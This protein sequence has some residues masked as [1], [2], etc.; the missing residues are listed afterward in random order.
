MA[1]GK[2]QGV[3][4]PTTPTASRVI[5][6]PMPGRTLA[7]LSPVRRRASPAKKS[8]ICAAR[9][10]SPMPFRKGFALFAGKQPPEFVLARH[11]F[12]C[13]LAQY[14]LTLQEAG[15]RPGREGGLCRRDGRLC[16]GFRCRSGIFADN[17]AWCP[18]DWCSSGRLRRSSRR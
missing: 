17:V 18:M 15:P 2:F 6:T 11:D 3:M 16:I 1:I 10:V 12:I 9:I 8:K 5:S 7:T 14:R 4:M 13:G